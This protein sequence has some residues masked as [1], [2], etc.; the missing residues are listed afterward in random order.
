[1]YVQGDFLVR[2]KP[3]MCSEGTVLGRIYGTVNANV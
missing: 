3:E 2:P 1:M